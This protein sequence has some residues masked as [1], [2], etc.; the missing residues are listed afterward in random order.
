MDSL[1]QP[2]CRGVVQLGCRVEEEQE[3]NDLW[4]LKEVAQNEVGCALRGGV[5]GLA[6]VEG[7][8]VGGPS[9]LELPLRHEQEGGGI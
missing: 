4:R 9:L 2:V 3:V 1:C 6:R 8:D 7:E 5:K